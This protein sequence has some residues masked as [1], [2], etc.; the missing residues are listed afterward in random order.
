MC[1]IT[2]NQWMTVASGE[3]LRGYFANKTNPLL[4]LNFSGVKIFESATVD[5]HILLLSKDKNQGVTFA[6][7]LNKSNKDQLNSLETF[8]SEHSHPMNYNSADKWVILSDIEYDIQNKI[9]ENAHSITDWHIK[10]NFGIKTGNNDAFIIDTTTKDQILANCK[11]KDER[12]RTAK[13]LRQIV[14]G[15]DILRFGYDWADKWLVALYPAKDYNIEDYPAIKNYLL[16]FAYKSLCENNHED[17]AKNNLAD[18][19]K[20]KLMQAGKDIT[21]NGKA[22]LNSR[23]QKDKSRKRTGNKWFETQDQISFW[24][25]FDKPKIL[26]KRI[27]SILRFAYD[28]AGILGL[29]STCLA[30]GD[31]LEVLCCIF[32]SKMGHYL[33]KDSPRTGTGDLLISVQAVEPLLVPSP[34]SEQES[35][36]IS[37]LNAQMQE[38]SEETDAA[39]ANIVYEM[40]GINDK[41]MR[42]YI[43]NYEL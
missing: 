34:T 41:K 42:E 19:C 26:W 35:T 2:K 7:V 11:D 15:K 3:A 5:T 4:L 20:Q 24:K 30:T 1:Y 8:V 10:I 21:I 25:E 13:V 37:L 43:N 22:V 6:S 28:D 17:I 32:N 12:E 9:K 38:V 18:Y 33:L 36:L 31:N 23:G 14:R 27:G 40:Y 39:I 29:D 16:S